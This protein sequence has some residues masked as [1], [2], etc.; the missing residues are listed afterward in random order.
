MS[1]PGVPRLK[2]E[3]WVRLIG[4]ALSVVAEYSKVSSFLSV[5]V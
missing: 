4:V 3:C 1:L 5:S 2:Y